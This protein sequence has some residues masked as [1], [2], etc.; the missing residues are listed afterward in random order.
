[1]TC[2]EFIT[3]LMATDP[4]LCPPP[5]RLAMRDHAKACLFCQERIAKIPNPSPERIPIID[6]KV[7]S[8]NK[9]DAEYLQSR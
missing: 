3:I 4:Q 5:I 8:M 7:A 6:A 9:I 1:M 2:N